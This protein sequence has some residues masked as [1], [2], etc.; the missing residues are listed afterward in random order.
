M[1]PAAQFLSSCRSDRILTIDDECHTPI[2]RASAGA[3][4]AERVSKITMSA[5]HGEGAP[6]E[7]HARSPDQSVRNGARDTRIAA[8]D[9]SYCGETAV[10][11]VAQHF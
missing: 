11:G 3:D 1:S 2:R 7:K 8:P 5:R 4:I 10:E 6:G 9:I